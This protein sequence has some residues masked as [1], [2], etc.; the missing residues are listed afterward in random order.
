MRRATEQDS[1]VAPS[2]GHAAARQRTRLQPAPAAEC[3]GGGPRKS[4]RQEPMLNKWVSR[5]ATPQ[6][7][8]PLARS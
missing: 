3:R 4:L 6:G 2:A 7:Q 1:L 5:A 8:V